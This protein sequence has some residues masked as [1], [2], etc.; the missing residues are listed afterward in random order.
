M[1]DYLPLLL[2]LACPLMMIFMMRG[3]HGGHDMGAEDKDPRHEGH[4]SP[5]DLPAEQR[6]IDLERQVAE[7]R[8]ERDRTERVTR[9]R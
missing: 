9:R 6:I 8:A 3:M 2:I 1:G 5:V 4:A 7:L